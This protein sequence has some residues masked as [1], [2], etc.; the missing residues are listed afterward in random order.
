MDNFWKIIFQIKIN[1]NHLQM[2]HRSFIASDRNKNA[3][4]NK[5]YFIISVK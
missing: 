1:S 5:F 4:Q 3:Y 2:D